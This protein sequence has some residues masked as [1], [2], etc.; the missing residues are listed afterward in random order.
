ML[1]TVFQG[2]TWLGQIVQRYPDDA[3]GW[4]AALMVTG[5]VVHA[6]TR[7]RRRR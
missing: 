2:V 1:A 7:R 5:L 3:V 6:L 4:C